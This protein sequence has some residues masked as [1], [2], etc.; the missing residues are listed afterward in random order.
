MATVI[1]LAV[2]AAVVVAGVLHFRKSMRSGCCGT[3]SGPAVRQAKVSDR[4]PAHYPYAKLL[5]IDGMTC[6]NC[7]RHVQNALGA[8]DGTLARVDLGERR[9]LVRMKRP[10]PDSALRKAV[11]DAGYTVMS[12]SDVEGRKPVT[13]RTA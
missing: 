13:G 10:L 7:A 8:L 1:I 6:Q 3:D 11:L 2:I 5:A 4:N 9:A 12:V